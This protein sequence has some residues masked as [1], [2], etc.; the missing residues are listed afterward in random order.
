[1]PDSLLR[2]AARGGSAVSA[3][4]QQRSQTLLDMRYPPRR[5]TE[6]DPKPD[7]TRSNT[8]TG[9]TTQQ[10]PLNYSATLPALTPQQQELLGQQR[11]TNTRQFQETSNTLNLERT[12]A[13]ADAERRRGVIGEDRRMASREGMQ[14]LA[15]RGVGRSPMFVNPFERRLATQAQRQ[16]GEL[17]SGLAG[18][19]AQLDAALRQAA[20]T[21]DRGNLDLDWQRT[22][23]RSDVPGLLGA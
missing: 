23:F 7:L 17:E 10:G 8:S 19:L 4:S 1:M 5:R 6:P 13:E 18:T 11:R 9:G 16:I 2:A 14:T 22:S 21:R 15:G 3:A 12:R 20:I